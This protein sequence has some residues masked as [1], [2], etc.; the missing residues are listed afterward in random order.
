MYNDSNLC[1]IL[2]FYFIYIIYPPK[3]ALIP[4]TPTYTFENIH[5]KKKN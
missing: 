4:F 3:N 5:K 2:C 1:Y